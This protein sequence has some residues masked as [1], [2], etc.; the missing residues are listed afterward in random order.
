MWP[1]V[2]IDEHQN[3][4][5][6]GQQFGGLSEVV[7]LLPA[8][9]RLTRHDQPSGHVRIVGHNLVNGFAGRIG[10]ALDDERE[11]EIAVVLLQ[12]S[13]KVALQVDVPALAGHENLG[14]AAGGFSARA[15]K[16]TSRVATVLPRLEN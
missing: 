1:R 9:K 8:V 16:A 4:D 11:L 13:F 3:L 12:Q 7:Y 10:V 2:G 6:L 5:I 15:C 14:L